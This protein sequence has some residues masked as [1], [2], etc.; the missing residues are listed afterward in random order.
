MQYRHH[1]RI[2][3]SSPP[4]RFSLI[5][6][7]RVKFP[8]PHNKYT[9]QLPGRS[10]MSFSSLFLP[11]NTIKAIDVYWLVIYN[12]ETSYTFHSL[13]HY[14]IYDIDFE[15]A[16]S[17]PH[18][19]YPPLAMLANAPRRSIYWLLHKEPRHYY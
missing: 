15:N 1:R 18:A 13:G 14:I 17:Q 11:T 10:A 16:A 8:S 3:T 12:S 4:L 9:R 2:A 7:Q 19:T 5:L 6:Y